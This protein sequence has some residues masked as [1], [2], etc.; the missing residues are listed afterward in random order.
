MP[1][2]PR[3]PAPGPDRPLD[4]LACHIIIGGGRTR[5]GHA[6]LSAPSSVSPPRDCASIASSAAWLAHASPAPA[7]MRCRPRLEIPAFTGMI[8]RLPGNVRPPSQP[9]CSRIEA[10][11]DAVTAV[12]IAAVRARAPLLRPVAGQG[13]TMPIAGSAGRCSACGQQADRL[14][15]LRIPGFCEK[16][17]RFSLG[18]LA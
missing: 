8:W 18:N 6:V 14:T 11:A 2:G 7:L 17:K 9:A 15:R 4:L 1:P 13:V 16:P 10:R 12:L 3:P 5:N